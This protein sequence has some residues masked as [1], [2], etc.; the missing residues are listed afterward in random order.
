MKG[1]L[2]KKSLLTNVINSVDVPPLPLV[3]KD[4]PPQ[5]FGNSDDFEKENQGKKA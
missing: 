3:S 1:L 4:L 5:Q 2:G